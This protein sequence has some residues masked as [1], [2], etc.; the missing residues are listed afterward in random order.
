MR[1]RN[2]KEGGGR[3]RG[4]HHSAFPLLIKYIFFCIGSIQNI[5]LNGVAGSS[6]IL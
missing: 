3:R 6:L 1:W 4:G 2:E 5:L